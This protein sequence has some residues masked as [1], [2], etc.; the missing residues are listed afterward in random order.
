[1]EEKSEQQKA[2]QYWWKKHLLE[3]EGVKPEGYY[4]AA[5]SYIH[6]NP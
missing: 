2:W 5:W 6:F 4:I 1:M 3:E